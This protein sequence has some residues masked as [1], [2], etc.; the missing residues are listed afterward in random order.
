VNEGAHALSRRRFAI[1]PDWLPIDVD[2]WRPY[3]FGMVNRGVMCSPY[4][5]DEPV[6]IYVQHTEATSTIREVFADSPVAS[7]GAAGKVG[8]VAAH[9]VVGLW[10]TWVS[11][12]GRGS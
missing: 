7:R 9:E 8:A 6:A 3:W 1:P 10:R 11:D 2:L 5:W 4:W 12:P